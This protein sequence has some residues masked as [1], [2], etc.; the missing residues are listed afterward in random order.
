MLVLPFNYWHTF[1]TGQFVLNN[2]ECVIIIVII[3]II[4]IIIITITISMIVI[5][6]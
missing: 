5:I 2:T 1:F 3:M 6:I 4:I